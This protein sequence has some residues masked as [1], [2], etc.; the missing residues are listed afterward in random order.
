MVS[1]PKK[2]S[3]L[4]ALNVSPTDYAAAKR[5]ESTSNMFLLEVADLA[6]KAKEARESSSPEKQFEA[7]CFFCK[8]T[9]KTAVPIVTSPTASFICDDCLQSRS[10]RQA[11]SED[12]A[13]EREAIE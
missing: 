7:T 9:H 2:K 13:P 3:L 8:K 1:L 11:I 10:R 4:S 12:F 6:A 5:K